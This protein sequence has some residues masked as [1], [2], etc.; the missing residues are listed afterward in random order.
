MKPDELLRKLME[1]KDRYLALQADWDE[2]VWSVT[3]NAMWMSK[4]YIKAAKKRK[5][6]KK[7]KI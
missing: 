5:K 6:P 1:A 4:Q 7:K 3:K 2:Y